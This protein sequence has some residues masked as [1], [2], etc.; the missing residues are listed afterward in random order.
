[1]AQLAPSLPGVRFE[2]RAPATEVSP[3]RTDIA[4]FIGPTWRGP[5]GEVVRVEGWRQYQSLFGELTEFADTPYAV[6]GYFENGG[7]IAYVVRLLAEPYACA[8]GI[9][10]VGKVDLATNTWDPGAPAGGGFEA[11]SFRITATSPGVWANGIR[12]FFEYRS[13]GPN[14]RPEVDVEVRPLR[15]PAEYLIGLP[16]DRLIEEVAERSRLIRLSIDKPAP[17]GSV[18]AGPL[19][20]VWTP[21]VTLANGAETPASHEDYVLAAELLAG[22]R[23]VALM[24]A[25]DLATLPA[26]PEQR[27][28]VLGVLVS[29]AE[30]RHDR[31]VIAEAPADFTEAAAILAWLRERRV[32][33]DEYFPRSL[34]LYHPRL[35]V[36]DPLGGVVEPLRDVSPL[37]HVAGVISRLDRERGAHHTPANA[38]LFEAVDLVRSH[39][40]AEL[41]ALALGGVNLIRCTPGYGLVVW[42]G[43]TAFDTRLGN[44]GLFIAH[45]RLIHRLIR[46]IRRIA[47]P[48]VFEVNGPDLWLIIARAITSVLLE[49]WQAGAL[50][51]DIPEQAFLVRCD[52]TTNPPENEDLGQVLCEVYVAPAVPMEFITLRIAIS[53]EGRLEAIET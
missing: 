44:S 10:E 42:G 36:P 25:P 24:T 34:A 47:E 17:A 13:R 15:G 30:E 20:K 26:A 39:D 53:R 38:P 12:V 40:P 50:K 8:E 46:A 32:A 21:P 19:V 29:L 9:W 33:L 3:L 45:R 5:V 23:E 31:Q 14:R 18:G 51:G 7:E 11:A 2:V 49:A 52:E 27:D 41:G 35:W 28:H 1:M 43:R 37:G 48:L 4:G 6:R 22:E 16:A